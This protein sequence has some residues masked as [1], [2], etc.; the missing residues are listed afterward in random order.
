[1]VTKVSCGCSIALVVAFVF[2]SPAFTHDFAQLTDSPVYGLTP[3][4]ITASTGAV[5]GLIGVIVGGLALRRAVRRIGNSGRS[6]A[7]ISL[8][9]GPIA[10]VIGAVVVATA[11]SGVGTGK[12]VAGGVV[13]LVLA[14]IATVLGGLA[15]VRAHEAG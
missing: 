6:G 9:L 3:E 11:D 5:I 12:G 10:F 4:R 14:L 13:A 15:L 7:V 8:V 1:V 2:A